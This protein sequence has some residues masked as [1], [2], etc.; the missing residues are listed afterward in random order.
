MRA[1]YNNPDRA[2]E[3]LVTGI[4]ATAPGNAPAAAPPAAPPAAGA[5]AAA[6]AAVPVQPAAAPAAGPQPFNMFAPNQ[7]G[8]GAAGGRRT[9][10][11]RR[12]HGAGAAALCTGA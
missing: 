6:A 4:P 11:P 12:T 10:R 9:W 2:Y 5:G 7:G 3:Y 8:G 1:A